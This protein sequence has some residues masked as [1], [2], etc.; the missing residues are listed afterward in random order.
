MP[1]T[2]CSWDV[3]YDPAHNAY[4]VAISLPGGVR[5]I[6]QQSQA[7][8]FPFFS[9]P[10]I[11][12]WAQ[13]QLQM[14]P[15][16]NGST[17]ATQGVLWNLNPDAKDKVV[18]QEAQG[19]CMDISGND[20]WGYSTPVL[21]FRIKDGNNQHWTFSPKPY[22]PHDQMFLSDLHRGTQGCTSTAATNAQRLE[23]AWSSITEDIQNVSAKIGAQIDIGKPFR[24][25]IVVDTVIRAWQTVAANAATFLKNVTV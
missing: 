3:L 1:T 20:G 17:L 5:V 2:V 11:I 23:G 16:A 15:L 9:N 21:S 18:L 4:R 7:L 14:I 8:R 12:G 6:G 22:T 19:Y 25:E 24:S 10:T 13:A